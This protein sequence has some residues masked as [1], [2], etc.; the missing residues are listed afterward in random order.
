MEYTSFGSTGEQVSRLGLGCMRLPKDESVAVALIRHAIDSGVT[1]LDTAYCYQDS[2]KVVGKALK[3]GYRD[4]VLLATKAPLWNIGCHGDFGRCL[5]EQLARLGTDHV[6]VYLL[7]NLDAGNLKRAKLHDGFG[8]L[9]DIT[10]SGKARY[11]GFSMHNSTEVF[12]QVA[13]D[14]YWDMAQIQLNIL[15]EHQQVGAAGLRLGAALGLAM[16]IMEPL[17]GGALLRHAPPAARALVAQHPERRSLAE[18]CFRWLY[19]MPEATVVLSG[20]STRE[21]LDEDLRIFDR[22]SPHSLSEGDAAFVECLVS[23]YRK[24]LTVPCTGCGYCMPCP[25]GVDIPAVLAA[26]NTCLLGGTPQ[27]NDRVHYQNALVPNAQAADRCVA[28]RAC[29]E[30]CPQSLAVT[31]LLVEAHTA[32]SKSYR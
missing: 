5:D 2:E 8:F 22:S 28:C 23:A 7:H 17:R 19:D 24:S 27:L 26:F 12:S 32:L 25:Q 30:Q 13:Q 29:E 3:G 14:Y 31:R 4:K 10:Q 18:W 1:Y 21:H 20:C 9:H 16:V 15:D 11:Q 6:D